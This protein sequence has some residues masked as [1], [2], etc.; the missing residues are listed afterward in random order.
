M[1]YDSEVDALFI[2]RCEATPDHSVDH[3]EGVS[4]I[5]DAEGNVNAL[6]ILD[7]QE[8]LARGGQLASDSQ[9]DSAAFAAHRA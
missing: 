3:E 4:A 2:K 1:R 9:P 8:R 6:E 7:F 5:V